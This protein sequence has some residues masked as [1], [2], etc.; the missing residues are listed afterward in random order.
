VVIETR[1][2][3][4]GDKRTRMCK[5]CGKRFVTIER[6]ALYAG[7]ALGYIEAS[8]QDEDEAEAE[9]EPEPAQPAAPRKPTPFVATLDDPEL[10]TLPAEVQSQLIE[11]WNNSR[12]SKHGA[13]ATWTETAWQL[14][15]RRV[16]K[17][18][19]AKRQQLVEAGVEHGWQA[20]KPEYLK[21]APA[22]EP[23]GLAPKA[24][25]MQ[26][27]IDQWHATA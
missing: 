1:Q 4:D 18:S 20:L 15:V 13:G 17:L 16:A 10:V 26:E 27:A 7:R 19:P 14:S 12:R 8:Y 3:S 9:P 22:A 23:T 5:V 25:A 6:V 24:S 2:K 11:W 21:T